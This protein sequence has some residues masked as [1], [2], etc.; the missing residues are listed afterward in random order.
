MRHRLASSRTSG[1]IALSPAFGLYGRMALLA[2]IAAVGMLFM[3]GL[4][5]AG[6][7]PVLGGALPGP[8]PLFPADNWW[9]TDISAA[10]GRDRHEDRQGLGQ[11]GLIA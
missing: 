7:G 5:A 11:A 1:H 8:L 9:N 6:P 10:P 4:A 3:S 2:L